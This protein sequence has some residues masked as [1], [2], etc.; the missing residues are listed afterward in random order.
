M[1][2]DEASQ[3]SKRVPS[4]SPLRSP[5]NMRLFG[6]SSQK[7]HKSSPASKKPPE[8]L[9]RAVADC[10]SS[11]ALNVHGNPTSMP[12]EAART[13]R[14]Y[15][16]NPATVDMAY[17]VLIDHALAERDRSPSVVPRCIAL[18][19]RFLLRYV[20]K[21][22][23]LRQIDIFCENSLSE[24]KSINNQRVSLWSMALSQYSG[25]ASNVP[26][27]LL[28]A[29]SF[30]SASLVKSLNYVRSLVAQHFPKLSFQPLGKYGPSTSGKQSL[31]SLST[32]LDESL[33]SHLS[34]SEAITSTDLP[35][36]KESTAQSSVIVSK[37]DRLDTGNNDQ[38]IY[39]DLL[40][41]RLSG[42]RELRSPYLTR[43]SD[44]HGLIEVGAAALLIDNKEAK[45]SE[46]SWKHPVSQDLPDVDQLLQ[47][48]LATTAANFGSV[49]NH[50]KA[51]AASKR[52][53][54][55]P[56]QVWENIP[57][58]TFHPRAHPLFQYRH[59][60]EQLP[61]RL[62]PAEISEVIAE[63]CSEA[64]SMNLN[65]TIS[66]LL[67]KH[68][69]PVT[70]VAVGVLIKL[71]IDMYLMNSE[72]AAPLTLSMLEDMLSSQTV[73][74]RVRVFDLILNLGVHAHLLEPVLD[75]ET[76]AIIE[77]EACL[78]TEGLELGN[79][80]RGDVS[81]HQRMESIKNF[82]C[83]LL[84][85][86]FEVLHLLVQTEEKEEI[87]WASAL[88]CLFYLV[89]D[90]SKILRSRL[91]YLDIRGIKALLKVCREHSW[92]EIV[93][94]KLICILTNMF[95]QSPMEY[96][97]AL[98]DTPRFL[99][100]QV[101][102]LGGINFI[103]LE[104][105]QAKTSEEKRNLFL[106]LFDYALHQINQECLASGASAYSFDE[107]QPVVSMLT[108]ADAPEAFYISV[109]HGV[110]GI[111]Q[112]L[113]KSIFRAISRSPNYEHL[114]LLLDKILGKLDA[115]ISAFTHV[116]NE[117]AHMIQ[118]TKAY[119]STTALD[120][121][122]ESEIGIR[123]RFSWATLHTL[124]HSERAACR[125]HGYIWIVELLLL[126]ISEERNRSIWLNVENFEQQIG[127]AGSQ[128]LVSSAVQLP[129]SIM[130]GLLK[131]KHNFIRRGFL[132]VLERFLMHFKI[133]LDEAEQQRGIHNDIIGDRKEN[134]LHKANA[135]I[136]IM[137]SA[138]SLVVHETD[139]LNILKMCDILF[140]QLCLRLPTTN[141]ASSRHFKLEQ[142]TCLANEINKSDSS[143]LSQSLSKVGK[144][145]NENSTG[146]FCP[147]G[148][149]TLIHETASMAALVLRGHAIVPVQLMARVPESL[150][151]WP[152]IQL[153][154]A[155]ADDIALGVAVGSEGRA[156]LPGSTSDIRAALLL[157]LIGKCSADSAAF[158]EVEGEEFFRG[159][160]DD[161][162]PRV[163]YCSAAFLL[164]RM[165]TEDAVNYQRTLQYLIVKAQQCNNEKLLENPYL[166]M[167]GILQLAND[168]A[169]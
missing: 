80:V 126:E 121:L 78:N 96:P 160:L 25:A 45:S 97:E 107:I 66:P 106:V 124:L 167:R 110:D 98:A 86:L 22:Q 21:E 151:Y 1:P 94:S 74:S 89:C 92:A 103:C 85:I 125:H 33:T 12:S 49:D 53:K 138:L 127:V 145:S 63:A 44:W 40:N 77:N 153:A 84:A 99:V 15:L 132:F 42:D 93:H 81:L 122:G 152:L 73:A 17:N 141:G 111:E 6:F 72:S 47:P 166:Q 61:L 27:S 3:G 75:D 158:R 102:L 34:S 50:L 65:V 115:S 18:L 7:Q 83:W 156:N 35:Q 76:P 164:K 130:C 31:V 8:P 162:D 67:A 51:I 30:A 169:G 5:G 71:V 37:L 143:Y 133:L 68:K 95:Y 43:E 157:L 26:A 79:I 82:E 88:S 62:N 58:S 123:T 90:R 100:E 56:H 131:S 135:V 20:P 118:L 4:Y 59:Y 104:Y 112:L 142:P 155:V 57:T 108:H 24:C 119:R 116:D 144:I 128:D 150:F 87:V 117:F 161:T 64:S 129:I 54:G 36:G 28:P 136:G 69:R 48:S 148:E 113:R 11:T 109:K 147:G 19:K 101:E 134:R 16:A 52:R 165:M 13:L 163:A 120:E 137:C 2:A 70:E 10:L 41:W 32:L 154:G 146:S 9:R 139:H 114:E 14:D 140:S 46:K 38:Y 55:G 23:I 168:P 39:S 60:S 149:P 91:E 159:L 105:S 29:S